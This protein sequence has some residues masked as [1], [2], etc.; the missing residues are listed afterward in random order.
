MVLTTTST[1]Y[2]TDKCCVAECLWWKGWV[3]IHTALAT[4]RIK[5]RYSTDNCCIAECL[6]WKGWVVIHTALATT[7]TRYDTDK[8]C[9]AECLWW[10]GWVVIHTALATL[11]A[12]V[13]TIQLVRTLHAESESIA[14]QEV[15]TYPLLFNI[16]CTSS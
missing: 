11:L 5:P 7:S 12:L 1:R 8:C 14:F 4:T 2:D 16:L 15:I 3:V 9:V 13:W 10:K 6:W